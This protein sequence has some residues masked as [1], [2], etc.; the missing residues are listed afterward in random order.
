MLSVCFEFWIIS[1]V[2]WL[3]HATLKCMYNDMLASEDLFAHFD[4]NSHLALIIIR[5][6]LLDVCEISTCL[7]K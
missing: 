1:F 6:I 3:S 5:T 2:N 4:D 7:Y